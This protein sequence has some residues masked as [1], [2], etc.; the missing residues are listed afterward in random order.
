MAEKFHTQLDELKTEILAMAD[1]AREMLNG[2]VEA[3]ISQDT[4][5][6]EEIVARKA[7]I[8]EMNDRLEERC[9]QMIA[10][11]QP[12]ATDM[13]KIA[14]GLK[15]IASSDRIGRYGKDIAKMVEDISDKP[16]LAH[17]LS[18]PHMAGLVLEMVDDA[19]KAY[20]TGDLSLIADLS[21]RDDAVEALR[22]SIFREAITYMMEDPKN[23]SRCTD[24]IMMSRYLERC[25]DH[26]CKVAENVHYM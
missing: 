7:E 2:A 25:A 20:E 14:C 19:M 26:A 22:Y 15:V 11:Y 8:R 16:H 24:Y 9:Y 23:I 6:A 10:L 18:I 12:M 3:M 5:A 4:Q 21:N 1:L 13:R 17:M